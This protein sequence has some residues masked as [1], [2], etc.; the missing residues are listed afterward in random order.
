MLFCN[1]L[2]VKVLS[3]TQNKDCV[4]SLCL[5]PFAV[6]TIR[7]TLSQTLIKAVCFVFIK[8]LHYAAS[9]NKT[10]RKMKGDYYALCRFTSYWKS[11]WVSLL[12]QLTPTKACANFKSNLIKVWTALI[13]EALLCCSSVLVSIKVRKQKT[14]PWLSIKY[15]SPL[16]HIRLYKIDKD[17]MFQITAMFNHN[18]SIWILWEVQHCE[19]KAI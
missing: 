3:E 15:E 8:F 4:H 19:A 7:T 16:F 17:H 1:H 14:N 5:S 12:K 11:Y 10:G 2:I 18:L 9:R 6:H 13:A